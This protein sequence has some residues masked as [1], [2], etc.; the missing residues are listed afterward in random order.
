MKQTKGAN[1]A[2][3]T[4]SGV[5]EHGDRRGQPVAGSKVMQWHR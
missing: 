3:I 2:F 1:R 4:I 5:T